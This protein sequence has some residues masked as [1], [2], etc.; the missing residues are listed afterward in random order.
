MTESKGNSRSLM[1]RKLMRKKLLK[2]SKSVRSKKKMMIRSKKKRKCMTVMQKK[3]KESTCLTMK[4]RTLEEMSVNN[5]KK[6]KKWEMKK[7]TGIV[8]RIAKA[9]LMEMMTKNLT[10]KIKIKM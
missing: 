5:R 7:K 6:T 10:R 2:K 9:M 8:R 4:V 3:M 1:K